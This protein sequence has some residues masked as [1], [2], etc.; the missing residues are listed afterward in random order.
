MVWQ[1]AAL[2]RERV[3][4]GEHLHTL[5]CLGLVRSG[6]NAAIFMSPHSHAF[7]KHTKRARLQLETDS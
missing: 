5:E 3:H 1:R 6:L 4:E 7:P 2:E